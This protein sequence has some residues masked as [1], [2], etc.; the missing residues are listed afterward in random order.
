MPTKRRIIGVPTPESF[1]DVWQRRAMA[2]AVVAVRGVISGGSIPPA[3]SLSRLSDIELGW[4]VAAAL[5]GWIKARSEQ[6]TA[7][8]WDMEETLRQTSLNPQPWDEGVVVHILP[9]LGTMSVDWDKPLGSWSRND[10]VRFLI[11]ALSSVHTAMV[12]RDVGGNIAT[13]VKCQPLDQMQR[14]ASAEADGP[15]LAPGELPDDPIER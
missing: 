12:A 13:P 5:F 9:T 1:E 2:A 3:T 4:I 11:N 15:L 10:M 8:G 6:A 14:T 7:E